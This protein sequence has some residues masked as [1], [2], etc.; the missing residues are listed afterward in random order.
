MCLAASAGQS[1]IITPVESRQSMLDGMHATLHNVDVAAGDYGDVQS[2]FVI[3]EEPEPMALVKD[4]DNAPVVSPTG[5]VLD[6]EVA[7]RIISTQFKP[8]GSLVMGDRGV[9]QLSNS[10]TMGEGESFKA[11]I[12]GVVYEVTIVD[13]TSESYT[14]SLGT[15]SVE[16][17][18]LTTTGSN[19]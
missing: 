14:L 13:V 4:L 6:D 11:E 15:A 7:L 9:L 10:Q 16:K 18:F 8:F 17:T 3:R 2:P 5:K 19:Q 1:Q 12:Q